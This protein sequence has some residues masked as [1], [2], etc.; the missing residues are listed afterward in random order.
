MVLA[1]TIY[2]GEAL[3]E[4]KAPAPPPAPTPKQDAAVQADQTANDWRKIEEEFSKL[5]PAEAQKLFSEAYHAVR[6]ILG[7]DDVLVPPNILAQAELGD[8]FE[9]INADR[10]DTH[11][12]FGNPDAHMFSS[13]HGSDGPED[14]GGSFG[15]RNGGGRRIQVTRRSAELTW[16]IMYRMRQG[17]DKKDPVPLSEAQTKDLTKAIRELG[18][19]DFQER[20]GASKAILDL[21]VSAIARLEEA[22]KSN[23]DAEVSARI[24][25]LLPK[26]RLAGVL[27]GFK[28]DIPVPA[29]PLATPPP[30]PAP[31]K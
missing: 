3:G 27:A 23:R 6:G 25:K 21:G 13:V 16:K 14:E 9:T 31:A 17:L 22:L 10:P 7:P 29:A 8:H 30:A 28:I 5:S 20:E 1:A 24:K 11:S 12:A 26:L 19:E 2:G 18:S 15:Q 4:E